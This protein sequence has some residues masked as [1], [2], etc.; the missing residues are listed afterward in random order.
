M[1]FLRE[2]FTQK[3][4][5]TGVHQMT[6]NNTGTSQDQEENEFTAHVVYSEKDPSEEVIQ[7]IKQIADSIAKFLNEKDKKC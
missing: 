6:E 4:T 5:T 7:E 2:N 1:I 3:L